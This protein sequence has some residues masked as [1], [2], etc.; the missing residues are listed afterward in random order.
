VTEADEVRVVVAGAHVHV[1]R[2]VVGVRE[3]ERAAREVVVESA[4]E[5]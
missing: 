1:E 5:R 3:V 4:V 2:E